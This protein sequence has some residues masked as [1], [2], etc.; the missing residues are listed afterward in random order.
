ME[1]A[2]KQERYGDKGDNTTRHT[3]QYTAIIIINTTIINMHISL[4]HGLRSTVHKY[5]VRSSST[6]LHVLCSAGQ[7][8]DRDGVAATMLLHCSH[9]A[10]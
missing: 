7:D 4:V 3:I 1:R 2:K 5:L 8:K 10:A 9:H 6:S